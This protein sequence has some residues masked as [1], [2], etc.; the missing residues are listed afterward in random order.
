MKEQH[1]TI[2]AHSYNEDRFV[3]SKN[4]FAVIDGATGLNEVNQDNK[5]TSASL[6]SS[7]VKSHLT[8]YK[9]ND[10][11]EFLRS[12]SVLAI[13]NG[14][15]EDTSC[16]ISIVKICDKNIE[17]YSLG[18]CSILYQ[19]KNGNVGSFGQTKLPKLDEIALKQMIDYAKSNGVS[20]K[21]AREHI[22]DTLKKHRALKNTPDGY[23]VFAPSSQPNFIVDKL[24]L[25]KDEIQSIIICS[26]GFAECYNLLNIFE[27]ERQLFESD[28]SIKDIC[29][30][31]QQVAKSDKDYNLYPRFKLFDDT[32]AIRLDF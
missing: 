4:L 30:K 1:F 15:N 26:D 7:F 12:L 8:K 11:A 6:L 21:K 31:V 9:G 32:T 23:W 2:K 24:V 27:D 28:L 13:K 20:I 17:F 16:G 5:A 29:L 19:Y 22:N 10:V 14:H 25:Q 18:D 3:V